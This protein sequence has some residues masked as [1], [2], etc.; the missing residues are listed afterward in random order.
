MDFPYNKLVVI[1]SHACLMKVDTE[2][3]HERLRF[4]A[5]MCLNV[6]KIEVENFDFEHQQWETKLNL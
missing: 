5:V 4:L 3:E 1:Q 2:L 6:L